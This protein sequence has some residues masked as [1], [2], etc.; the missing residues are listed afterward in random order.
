MLKLLYTIVF[1]LSAAYLQA[2]ADY[3]LIYLKDGSIYKGHIIEYVPTDRASI[4][5]LDNRV[6]V[7]QTDQIMRMTVGRDI[8]IKKRIDL[9]QKGYYHNSLLGLQMGNSGY[10]YTPVTFAYNMV[11]GYR[12]KKHHL[13]VGLGIESHLGNWYAPVY[14]DY[15]YHILKGRTSPMLGINGGFMAPMRNGFH[16]PRDYSKGSFIG[17]RIGFVAYSNPHFAFLLNITYRYIHLSGAE[18]T[19]HPLWN[20]SYNVS[21]SASIHRVGIMMGFVIN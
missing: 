3:D 14:A 6:I 15:S 10:G 4:K 9:K 1:C 16:L 18:Y 11:N 12:I 19:L 8:V 2:Q 7:V 21:G 17:G 5:L 20:E 13:G